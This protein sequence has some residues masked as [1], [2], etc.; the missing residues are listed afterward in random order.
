M[1]KTQPELLPYPKAAK[2]TF[3][4]KS[5]LH[6]WCHLSLKGAFISHPRRVFTIHGNALGQ[7]N[8]AT[9]SLGCSSMAV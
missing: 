8:P 4:T 9:Y 5:Q 1:V 3:Q 6:I 2:A 7:T